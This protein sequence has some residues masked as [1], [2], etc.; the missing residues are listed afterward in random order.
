[1]N[2]A[3]EIEALVHSGAYAADERGEPDNYR[4]GNLQ[5]GEFEP[6]LYLDWIAV[7]IELIVLVD[8]QKQNSVWRDRSNVLRPTPNHVAGLM[9][10]VS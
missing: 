8:A 2:L 10:L 9:K 4:V 6:S 3:A 1:V 7:P 5:A